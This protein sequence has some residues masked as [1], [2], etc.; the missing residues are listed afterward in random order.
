MRT[1]SAA[2]LDE[3][4][5]LE[6]VVGAAAVGVDAVQSVC[7]AIARSAS[8]SMTGIRAGALPRGPAAAG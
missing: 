4:L 5:G 6:P 2:H 3:E 7:S 1:N 8:A